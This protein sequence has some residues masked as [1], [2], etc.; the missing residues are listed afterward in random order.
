MCSIDAAVKVIGE[1]WALLTL[2]ELIMGCTRFDE[3]VSNT[4]VSRDILAARLRSLE[5]AGIVHRERYAN[6]PIRYEYKLAEAGIQLFG[7]LHVMR[8]W[9]DRYVRDDPENIVTFHHSCGAKL[10]PELHCSACGE[11]LQVDSI[12]SDRDVHRS[13]IAAGSAS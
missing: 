6:K 5:E 7:L 2:R 10:N 11:V 13:D 3:I 9:G 1:K 4:G 8:D 12:T